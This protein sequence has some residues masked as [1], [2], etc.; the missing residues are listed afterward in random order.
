MMIDLSAEHALI[1]ARL[2]VRTNKW[3]TIKQTRYLPLVGGLQAR[4]FVL[5]GF[6]LLADFAEAVAVADATQIFECLFRR[7]KDVA[8]DDWARGGGNEASAAKL[9]KLAHKQDDPDEVE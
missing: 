6:R 3:K 4:G 7:L 8:T 2:H 9:V 1:T 5:L